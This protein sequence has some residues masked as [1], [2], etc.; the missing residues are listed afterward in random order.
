MARLVCLCNL[1]D[2]KEILSWLKK[3]ANST[4]EIQQFTLAGSSCGRC[5]PET[6]QIVDTYLKK[7]PGEKQKKLNFGF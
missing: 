3:G 7:K 5:L 1:V 2:E 6:D 4:K